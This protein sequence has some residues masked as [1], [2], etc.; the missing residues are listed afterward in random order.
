MSASSELSWTG[1]RK[2]GDAT[3]RSTYWFCMTIPLV[4]P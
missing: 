4:S 3:S 2:C 1:A